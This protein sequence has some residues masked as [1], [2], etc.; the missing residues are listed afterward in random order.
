MPVA[1]VELDCLECLFSPEEHRALRQQ[2]SA[3]ELPLTLLPF[4]SVGGSGILA[5]FR[6]DFL[7]VSGRTYEGALVAV[8]PGSLGGEMFHALWGGEERVS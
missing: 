4:Q 1:V 8:H 5:A 6:T 3:A 2:S 7:T